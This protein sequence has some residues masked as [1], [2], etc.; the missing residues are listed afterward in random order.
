MGRDFLPRSLDIS[1]KQALVLQLVQTL[2]L[3]KDRCEIIKWGE[4]L[5]IPSHHFTNFAMIC[6]EI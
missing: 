2:K 6:K 4:F 5:H 1:K 3:S